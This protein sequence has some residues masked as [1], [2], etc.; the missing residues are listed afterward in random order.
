MMT[1]EEAKMSEAEFLD[2]QVEEAQAAVK[3]TWEELKTSLKDTASLELWARR[4]PWVVTG[5]ALAGG[6]LVATML[7]SPAR[8]PEVP[9]EKE[10]EAPA[11]R[12]HRSGW[13]FGALFGLLR[14]IFGQ[15]VSTLAA[16]AMAAM[17]G[18]MMA[19]QT[20]EAGMAGDSD[21]N[22]HA[23]GEGPVPL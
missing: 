12:R 21:G 11:E 19:D 8:E 3:E 15:L 4:H 10:R 7:F 20:A 2:A 9:A 14:P 23:P 6:F 13:L 18:A 1:S 17:T 16:S 22:G 5:A